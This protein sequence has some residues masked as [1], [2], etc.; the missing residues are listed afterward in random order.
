MGFCG[1]SLALGNQRQLQEDDETSETS[2]DVDPTA[3][4]LDEL[5]SLGL[6]VSQ[7]RLKQVKR[8]ITKLKVHDLAHIHSSGPTRP[9]PL[10]QP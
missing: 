5:E 3:S 4:D 2:D 8:S 10:K 6:S 7:Y 9:H 1:M